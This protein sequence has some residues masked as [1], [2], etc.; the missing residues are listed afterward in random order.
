MAWRSLGCGSVG[1]VG[2]SEMND[3]HNCNKDLTETRVNPAYPTGTN[4]AEE[5]VLTT[6][7]R[8]LIMLFEKLVEDIWRMASR[9]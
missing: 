4:S 5:W 2:I 6:N 3:C 8:H 7:K 1:T 9:V